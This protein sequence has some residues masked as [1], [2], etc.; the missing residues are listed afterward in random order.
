MSETVATLLFILYYLAVGVVFA[1]PLALPTP[2]RWARRRRGWRFA[3]IAVLSLAAFTLSFIV[4]SQ[5]EI[6]TELAIVSGEA[7]QIG[8][9]P[10]PTDDPLLQQLRTGR[11]AVQIELWLR[12]ITPAGMQPA[13]F[14]A[15][16]DLC[17]L[18]DKVENPYRPRG[19]GFAPNLLRSLTSL[20]SCALLGWLLTRRGR[21]DVIAICSPARH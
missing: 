13:C 20:A 8:D 6:S 7:F 18:A 17:A 5:S 10:Q 12:S 14:A 11:N 4:W 15:S 2:R 21:S 16:A 19:S 1:L 9:Q 3:L